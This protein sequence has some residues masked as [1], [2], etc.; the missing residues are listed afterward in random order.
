MNE[1][2][3]IKLIVYQTQSFYGKGRIGEEIA[4]STTRTVATGNHRK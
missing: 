2:L 1:D 4:H 3:Q